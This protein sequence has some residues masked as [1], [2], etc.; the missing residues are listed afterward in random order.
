MPTWH[1]KA[2][3][4]KQVMFTASWYCRPN[5]ED[6]II[7]CLKIFLCSIQF[8]VPSFEL[9][10]WMCVLSCLLLSACLPDVGGRQRGN[11]RDKTDTQTDQKLTEGNNKILHRNIF[12]TLKNAWRNI[13]LWT[14][15]FL[16]TLLE[17]ALNNKCQQ[18]EITFK[19]LDKMSK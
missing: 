16:A 19:N 9:L 7:S 1:S 11:I 14:S 2:N 8:I 3:S 4:E 17:N 15:E 6:R 18:T 13:P 5:P 12:P 10:V